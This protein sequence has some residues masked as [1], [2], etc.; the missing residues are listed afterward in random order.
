[1]DLPDGYTITI[2]A[3]L[4]VLWRHD[5]EGRIVCIAVSADTSIPELR[6]I[7]TRHAHHTA[8]SEPPCP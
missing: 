8:R 5:S 4:A 1:M 6:A 3:G 7:A 2:T